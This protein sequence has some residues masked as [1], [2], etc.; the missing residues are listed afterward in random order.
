[1]TV[2]LR[3][4]LGSFPPIIWQIL[5]RM[6]AGWAEERRSTLRRGGDTCR[7]MPTARSLHHREVPPFSNHDQ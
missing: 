5:A 4:F 2:H 7:I 1:M 6:G 3:L